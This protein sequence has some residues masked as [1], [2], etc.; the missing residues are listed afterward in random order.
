MTM[1]ALT[2]ITGHVVV[3]GIYNYLHP[4]PIPYSL[5]H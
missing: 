1:T 3:T 2:F 5:C 4:L